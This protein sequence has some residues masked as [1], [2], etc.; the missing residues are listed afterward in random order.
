MQSI[1]APTGSVSHTYRPA[2]TPKD[3]QYS[4]QRR[5]GADSHEAYGLGSAKNA[6]DRVLL[7]R[8][9]EGNKAALGIEGENFRATL[10][11]TAPQMRALAARLLDAAHDIEVHPAQVLQAVAA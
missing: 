4:N 2:I 10:E 3:A 6:T 7:T 1:L 11:L 5:Y 8:Y 9:A